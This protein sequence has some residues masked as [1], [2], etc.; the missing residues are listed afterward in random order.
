MISFIKSEITH[1]KNLPKKAQTLLISFFFYSTAYPMISIFINAFIWKNSNDI[2]YLIYL[3]AGQFLM[4]PAAFLLGGILLKFIKIQHLYFIGT[5]FTAISSVLIIFLK[6]DTIFSFLLMGILLGIGAG[7]Y[8]VNRNYLTIRET[9]E[10]NRSY[11]FGLLFSF[12]TLIGLVITLF[13]GW[14][15]V[16]G[17]SYQL[18]MI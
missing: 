13:T 5:F 11:F 6:N 9:D 18:I 8:W 12:A 15:I 16:F 14:L 3:R 10:E 4:T 7:L 1:F 17:M 2:T